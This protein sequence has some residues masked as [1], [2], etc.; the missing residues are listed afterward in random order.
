MS[1]NCSLIIDSCCDL[2][3]DVV[4]AEGVKVVG[5]S[6]NNESGSHIDDMYASLTA[7]DFYEAMRGGDEPSTSQVTL[8]EFLEVFKQAYEEGKPAVLL[9]FSSALSGSYSTACIAADQIKQEHP[10]FELHV[11]DTKL[12]SI[13]EGLLAYE[14][15]RQCN[16]G[17]SAK[18]L[19][20]WA[21]EARWYVNSCFT[22]DELDH[23]RRGG[24]IPS[25]AA[26][27]GDKLNIKPMLSFNLDGTLSM[28]GM[29]RGRKKA[30]KSI[31]KFYEDTHVDGGSSDESILVG[32]ADAEN[33]A[34]WVEEHLRRPEGSLP[35]VRCHI[36][37]VIGSHVGPG[38]VAIAIW[39]PDRRK[40][41]SIAD[42]IA[43]RLSSEDE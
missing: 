19:A 30:L 4:D 22:I 38:M 25:A 15:V 7:H 34:K 16:R 42:R 14:A 41:A 10:D 13:A 39:G 9:S 37:P 2:P 32:S 40:K 23:L 27:V 28:T 6:Y 8:G 11:V 29:A 24:R 43:N 36:G 31:V 1:I 3:R 26:T 21:E 20:S 5:F 33:D 35:V 18:Q 17:L 12:A